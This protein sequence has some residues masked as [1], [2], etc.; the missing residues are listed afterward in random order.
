MLNKPR[1]LTPG[2]TPLP[3][4]VRLALA[5]DMIHHRKAGFQQIMAETQQKLRT[6]FGTCQPVLPLSCSGTGAMTAAVYSLFRPG[7]KVLV[8][9]AGKFG[10]RWTEIAK[11]RGLD[12][13]RLTV[14]WGKA[15]DP[16]DVANILERDKDICGVLTQMSETSTGVLQP[17]RDI[18]AIT[19]NKAVLLVVDGI[20]AVGIS[21]CPMDEWGVDCLLTGS[22]KG[23]MLPP[24]LAPIALSERAW[25]IAESIPPG[26]YYFNLPAERASLAKGQTHFTSPVNLIVGLNASLDLLLAN[27]LASV[28]RKQWAMTMLIRAGAQAMGLELFAKSSF[29]WGVTSVCMPK[30]IDGQQALKYAQENFGI[31]MAGG[32]DQLKGKIV[33]IGHMGWVDWGDCIAALCA[34]KESLVHC[35]WHAPAAGFVDAAMN[36]YASALEQNEMQLYA[37]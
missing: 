3:E 18:A 33:R 22:Q 13:V 37:L 17:V 31:I 1:L 34:L 29:A 14:D 15:A 6:L 36:A 19:R 28:Y 2:P 5:Q 23:L 12:P 8:I 25:Q 21:P 9:E 10:E 32:Q 26:C 4:R 35:G 27:G 24:G 30:G 7:Q 20:S 11:A 16:C